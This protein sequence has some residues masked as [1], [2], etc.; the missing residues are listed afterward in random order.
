MIKQNVLA[1]NNVL[2]FADKILWESLCKI[3]GGKDTIL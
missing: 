2:L 1:H 3:T